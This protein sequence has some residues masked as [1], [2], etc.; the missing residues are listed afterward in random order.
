LLYFGVPL[1]S[2]L[3][4]KDWTQVCRLLSNTLT[5]IAGQTGGDFKVLVAHHEAPDVPHRADPRFEFLQVD[6]PP[7]LYRREMMIDKSRKSEVIAE[8]VRQLGGGYIMYVDADDLVSNR[9]AEFVARDRAEHGYVCR[10]GYE[11]D[12]VTE[13]LR[14][15]PRFDRMCGTSKIMRW[16]V[17]ELPEVAF[18]R[19]GVPFRRYLDAG[20]AHWATMASADKRPL[21]TLPFA[22]VI[23]VLR[24]AGENHSIATN[25]IGW[26]RALVRRFVPGRRI[27]DEVRR[28]FA[29]P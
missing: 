28:E 13:T 10:V 12:A 4:S 27:S 29:I 24:H 14:W 18:A 8:R 5:S 3:I 16:P 20:H 7:P 15:S 21:K 23:Y 2:R 25:N 17:S 1:K 26:R 19:E 9:I 11:Y 22:A 6:F